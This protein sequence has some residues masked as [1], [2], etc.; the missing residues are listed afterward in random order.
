MSWTKPTGTSKGN[1]NIVRLNLRFENL[2]DHVLRLAYHSGSSIL[3]DDFGNT[4]FGAKAGDGPDTSVT[5]MGTDTDG[6]TNPE[7]LLEPKQSEPA[8]FQVWG[9]RAANQRQPLFHYDVTIDEIDATDSKRI[10]RQHAINFGDFAVRSL[11]PGHVSQTPKPE[12]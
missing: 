5:G 8:T 9:H 11:N 12:E 4:Y 3:A 10:L 2:T 7:F 6:K 1:Y